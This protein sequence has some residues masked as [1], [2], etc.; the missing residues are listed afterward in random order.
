[1]VVVVVVADV[2]FRLVERSNNHGR[3]RDRRCCVAGAL[4]RRRLQEVRWGTVETILVGLGDRGAVGHRECIGLV[5]L[6]VG[7]GG[8]HKAR[9]DHLV[10]H[11]EVEYRWEAHVVG[12]D[13]GRRH[14][15]VAVV[16]VVVVVVVAVVVG[17][18][19]EGWGVGIG[20]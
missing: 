3:D 15:G 12:C 1:M 10:Q 20:N 8:V 5:E 2:I 14:V 19:D 7:V 6:G 13:H 18:Y 11:R 4:G 17:S 9:V 16:V